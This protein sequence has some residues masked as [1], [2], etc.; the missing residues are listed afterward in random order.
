MRRICLAACCLAMALTL[1]GCRQTSSTTAGSPLTP[2]GPLAPVG[3]TPVGTPTTPSSAMG[4]F[5][6][7]TRVPPPPSNSANTQAGGFVP[8]GQTSS[9]AA[10][11]AAA[12]DSFAGNAATRSTSTFSAGTQPIGSGVATVGWTETN[13]DIRSAPVH[14]NAYAQPA[15]P[16]SPSTAPPSSGLQFSGMRVNDLTGATSSPS[17]YAAA[18]MVAT[19]PTS[20]FAQGYYPPSVDPAASVAYPPNQPSLAPLSVPVSAPLLPQ[21]V[22]TPASFP[23][24]G[25]TTDPIVTRSSSS[26]GTPTSDN[27]LPWRRPAA[28]Y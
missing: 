18:P 8:Y 24:N 2:I 15:L 12:Y 13:T 17:S 7:P 5:S 11:P 1:A 3:L 19:G 10:P 25:P 21:S 14:P 26:T 16:Q 22:G 9:I 27:D 20:G 6:A 4:S 28:Q 23:A